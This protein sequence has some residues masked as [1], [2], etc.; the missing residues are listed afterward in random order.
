M[1]KVERERQLH[2]EY[3]DKALQVDHE[4]RG[5][6]WTARHG[7][8]GHGKKVG[9]LSSGGGFGLWRQVSDAVQLV[10]AL[11]TIRA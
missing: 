9:D 11:T 7:C 5:G 6:Q 2:E 8:L 10:E 3:I 1:F 4:F